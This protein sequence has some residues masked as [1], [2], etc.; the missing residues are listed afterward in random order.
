MN[1]KASMSRIK[2]LFFLYSLSVLFTAC[3]SV[4][5]STS[6]QIEKSKTVGFSEPAAPFQKFKIESVDRAWKNFKNGNSISFLSECQTVADPSL[7]TL[8]RGIISSIDRSESVEK[9]LIT[10]N[11][12]EALRT[13]AIGYVDGVKSQFELVI[14][15]KNNCTYI[16]SYVGTEK[17]FSQ[18]SQQFEKFLSG[19]KAK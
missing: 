6:G 19:F 18:D 11:E 3:V 7:E 16:L 15:K 17:H 1:K 5:L 14:F 13:R 4:N 2:S 12:R 8:Y 10:Y 9:K